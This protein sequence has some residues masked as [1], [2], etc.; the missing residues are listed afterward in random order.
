MHWS[1]VVSGDNAD[2]NYSANVGRLPPYVVLMDENEFT[3]DNVAM[4]QSF[5][6][7]ASLQGAGSTD[8]DKND[9]DEEGFGVLRAS[10]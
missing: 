3:A 2:D 4:V 9:N 6:E 8:G 7:T 5:A 10:S 1:A